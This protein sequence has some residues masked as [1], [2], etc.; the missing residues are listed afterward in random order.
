MDSADELDRLLEQ[1]EVQSGVV[2]G[3]SHQVRTAMGLRDQPVLDQFE[4]E[5]FRLPLK[6][7]LMILGP[8]GTGKTTTLIKR[9]G[10]KL[11]LES[12]DA[13]ERQLAESASHQRPHQSSWLMFTPSELLKQYLKEAFNREQ[14]PASDAHIRTWLAYA[15]ILLAILSAF[16]VVQMVVDFR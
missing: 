5:I 2:A 15:M 12:L 10:Q 16:Y 13:D 7:R 3:I 8:P 9:L 1:A 4:G 6:S 11:D 14:V